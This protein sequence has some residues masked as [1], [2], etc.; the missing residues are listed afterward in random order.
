MPLT[1]TILSPEEQAF[2]QETDA[3][4]EEMAK[5]AT[6]PPAFIDKIAPTDASQVLEAAKPIAQGMT[7]EATPTETAPEAVPLTDPL[8]AAQSPVL[9]PDHEQ[10]TP[11]PE[12][13]ETPA[14]PSTP[15]LPPNNSGPW[16]AQ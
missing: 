8:T 3:K 13:P 6:V 14:A 15:Q 4:V 1:D 9:P 12:A 7:E 16:L 11:A 10:A 2:D 5:E